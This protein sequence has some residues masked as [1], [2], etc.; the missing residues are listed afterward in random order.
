NVID[1]Y[2][3]LAPGDPGSVERD[4]VSKAWTSLTCMVR[5]LL[6]ARTPVI[7][8]TATPRHDALNALK[9]HCRASSLYILSYDASSSAGSTRNGTKIVVNDRDFTDPLLDRLYKTFIHRA[10]G[11]TQ[12]ALNLCLKEAGSCNILVACNNIRSAVQICHDLRERGLSPILLHS[13]FTSQDKGQK[14]REIQKRM[15]SGDAIVVSTQVIEVGVNLDFDML[16]SDAAPIASLVQR[17][18]RVGR[19]I[20]RTP[21]EYFAIHIVYDTSYE[22]N[23]SHLYAHVYSL[24]FTQATV[25]FLAQAKNEGLEISWR[26]PASARVNNLLPYNKI[27]ERIYHLEGLS[28][29]RTLSIIL[30]TMLDPTTDAKRALTYIRHLRSLVRDSIEIPVLIVKEPLEVGATIHFRE[31]MFVPARPSALGLQVDPK[32]IRPVNHKKLSSALQLA[33][34][35]LVAIVERE[36]DDVTEVTA[37]SFKE[38]DQFY[39]QGYIFKDGRRVLFRALVAKPEAYSRE[40]GFTAWL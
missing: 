29:D 3:L 15:Q 1:E 11:F 35:K 6:E 18:G 33:N 31:D 13:Q 26:I 14:I 37:L 24:Q 36:K 30:R 21:A 4:F 22:Q 5:D 19:K 34:D 39:S 12:K 23:T 7:L 20:D 2:H 28:F 9:T 38:L 8:E 27:A 16:I 17:I 32:A 10:E 40:E 25:Q